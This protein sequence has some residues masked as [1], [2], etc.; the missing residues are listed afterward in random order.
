MVLQESGKTWT[1]VALTL[2]S[3]VPLGDVSPSTLSPEVRRIVPPQPVA[4]EAELGG[5]DAFIMEPAIIVEETGA[6]F[7]NEVSLTYRPEELV[8]LASG[9]DAISLQLGEAQVTPEVFARA[10]PMWDTTAFR[11][12]SFTNTTGEPILSTDNAMLD[13]YAQVTLTVD[14]VFVGVTQIDFIP[15]GAETEMAFGPIFAL[16][17]RRIVEDREEGDRGVLGRTNT[18]VEAARIEI[19]NFG[20]QSWPV[21]L[22]DRVPVSQQEDLVI[23]WSADPQPTEEDVDDLAGVMEWRFDLAPGATQTIDLSHEMR[24][25]NDQ[26]LR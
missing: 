1:D 25:P 9:Y 8:T 13:M 18:E 17:L 14:G 15:N 12:A 20:E 4:P 2:S 11:V 19:E 6:G 10:T 7:V 26:I 23:T 3:L 24:W 16:G 22:R 21:R 5:L